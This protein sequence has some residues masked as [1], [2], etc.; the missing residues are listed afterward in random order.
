MLGMKMP[1]RP[2]YTESNRQLRIRTI[3]LEANTTY[4]VK[5]SAKQ[6][7]AYDGTRLDG[8]FRGAELLLEF[9]DR[10]IGLD[11]LRRFQVDDFAMA[12]R[13]M[14]SRKRGLTP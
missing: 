11:F 3:G 14:P 4:F 9:R 12:T 8:E 1:I 13:V 5:L 10:S 6:I 2:I 7:Y